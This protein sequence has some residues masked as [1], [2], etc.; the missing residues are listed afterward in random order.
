VSAQLTPEFQFT[1]YAEDGLGNR[2]SVV[3]GYDDRATYGIDSLTFGEAEII[4]QPFDPDLEIRAMNPFVTRWSQLSKR[5]IIPLSGPAPLTGDDGGEGLITLAIHVRQKPLILRWDSS[6]FVPGNQWDHAESLTATNLMYTQYPL[7]DF[8]P[9][10]LRY[11]GFRMEF[12]GLE[13]GSYSSTD[14]QD[15]EG[16]TIRIYEYLVLFAD[17]PQVL[18]VASSTLADV[19]LYPNP[20]HAE[21]RV[22][23]PTPTPLQ[24]EALRCYDLQG[25]EQSVSA[26]VAGDVY[27]L[28]TRALPAG[29][30]LLHWQQGAEQ[31]RGLWVKR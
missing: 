25:R 27:R 3:L 21:A 15:T 18:N 22:Q 2:D 23:I 14:V 19:K 16:N 8:F 12:F 17:E 20:G 28:D 31:W 29:S 30:Y 10:Y 13:E 6:L 7:P 11:Q 1:L 4:N 5:S 24:A 26:A 9:R